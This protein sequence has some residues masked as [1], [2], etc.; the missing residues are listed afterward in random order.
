MKPRTP[1]RPAAPAVDRRSAPLEELEE[2]PEA[3][4][5][6]V[7]LPLEALEE[8]DPPEEEDPDPVVVAEADDPPED[9]LAVAEIPSDAEE[10]TQLESLLDAMVTASE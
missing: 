2:E 5:V 1:A 6:P 9:P 7:E 3:E 8:E 10:L 4:A